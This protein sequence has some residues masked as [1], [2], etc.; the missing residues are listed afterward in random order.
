MSFF[1]LFDGQQEEPKAPKGT[2]FTYSDGAANLYF[3]T[4][5][6]IEYAPMTPERSSSGFYSGGEPATVKITTEQFEAICQVFEQAQANKE[7]HRKNR[8]KG[9]GHVSG[10]LFQLKQKFF[11]PFNLVRN[12]TSQ[13]AI[14]EMLKALLKQ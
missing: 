12:S 3:I 11:L 2:I 6:I 14:E 1:D 10:D 13:I 7:D 5:T 4:T 8:L 9:S